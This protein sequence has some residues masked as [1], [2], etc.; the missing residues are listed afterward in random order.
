MAVYSV[1]CSGATV[2]EEGKGEGRCRAGVVEQQKERELMGKSDIK[3]FNS[4]Y[5]E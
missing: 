3:K 2:G 5:V 4:S 1:P